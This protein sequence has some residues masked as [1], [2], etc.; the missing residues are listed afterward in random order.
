MD[1]P[2]IRTH[3]MDYLYDFVE[4]ELMDDNNRYSPIPEKFGGDCR[5]WGDNLLLQY[6][7]DNQHSIKAIPAN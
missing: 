3:E 5:K 4:R 1:V 6:L 2:Y 7:R